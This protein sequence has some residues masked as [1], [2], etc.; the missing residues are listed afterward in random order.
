MR[1][2][3]L[4]GMSLF[5][6]LVV[7]YFSYHQITGILLLGYPLYRLTADYILLWCSLIN[8]LKVREWVARL[9]KGR[10]GL[11]ISWER[12]HIGISKWLMINLVMLGLMYEYL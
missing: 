10:I 1:I 8:E 5:F 12:R 4:I 3:L 9:S 7:N 2:I 6:I 11:N